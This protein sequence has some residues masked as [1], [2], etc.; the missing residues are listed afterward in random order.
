MPTL[1]SF[2]GILIQMFWDDHNPPH[3]HAK[4][5]EYK[6]AIDIRQ[7]CIM[8][9]ALPSRAKKLVLE[10]ATEHQDELL[11]DWELCQNGHDPNRIQPLN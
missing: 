2:Y 6:A 5:A 4:Y 9:G 11:V 8:E 10:W 1:C 7:L 3:F